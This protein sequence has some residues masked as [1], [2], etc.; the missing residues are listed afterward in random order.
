MKRQKFVFLL[1]VMGFNE[2]YLENVKK[3]AMLN[4]LFLLISSYKMFPRHRRILPLH[5][6]NRVRSTERRL[7][8]L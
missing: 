6:T 3:S 8:E 2:I 4:I 7:C 1:V 5:L